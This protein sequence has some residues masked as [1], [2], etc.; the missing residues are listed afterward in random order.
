[1]RKKILIWAG[2]ILLFS[3]LWIFAD[4]PNHRGDASLSGVSSGELET[5]LSL[6]WTFDAGK[7]LKSS[8]VVSGETLFFW[9]AP[10]EIFMPWIGSP[11]KRSG[12][13][14]SGLGWMHLL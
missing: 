14:I 11:A 10:L 3:P 5:E 9:V 12:K 8:P 1:M 6:E 13:K 7:F 2:A 4:W